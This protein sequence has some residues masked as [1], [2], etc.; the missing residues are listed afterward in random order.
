MLL[1]SGGRVDPP[2]AR[3]PAPSRPHPPGSIGLFADLPLQ[4]GNKEKLDV[5]QPLLFLP[6]GVILLAVGEGCVDAH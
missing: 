5:V 3:S 4:L 6:L 1:A 2:Y